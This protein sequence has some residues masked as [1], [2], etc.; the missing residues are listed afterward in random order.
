M[1][2]KN[3][4]RIKSLT[5]LKAIAMLLIFWWH[6][7]L[8][9]PSVDLGARCCEFFFVASG[10]LFASNHY[11][12]DAMTLI[13]AIKY[14]LKKSIKIYPIY[15]LTFLVEV[16]LQG[17]SNGT[18][19]VNAVLDIFMLQSWSTSQSVFFSFNGTLW[20]AASLMYSYLLGCLVMGLLRGMRKV[21]VLL[22][23]FAVCRYLIEYLN[24]KYGDAFLTINVHVNPFVRSL[25]FCCGMA[26]ASLGI[27]IKD[28][29]DKI[30]NRVYTLIEALVMVL[31]VG[32]V[33]KMEG[34]WLRAVYVYLFCA[35]VMVF[36]FDK[37]LVSCVV[38]MKPLL[39][40]G[41]IQLE[42][43]MI[44]TIVCKTIQPL[45]TWSWWNWYFETALICFCVTLCCVGIY[46][47]LFKRN[48]EKQMCKL[49]MKI[50]K[51]ICG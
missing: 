20:F 41:N 35:L 13:D 44:H 25:E 46:R 24:V 1:G 2:E 48:M 32:L 4:R 6:S 9:N 10:F 11:T 23:L 27:S 30:D 5:G 26:T 39:Y 19:I 15:L 34:I 8:P 38:S 7:A 42:F 50:E 49:V 37:G 12:N 43:Y 14:V 40:F 33:V 51:S 21:S 3:I 28:K 18:D 17:I 29:I 36:S 16:V 47:F 22:V 45:V 31:V